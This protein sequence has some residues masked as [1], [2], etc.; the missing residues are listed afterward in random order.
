MIL[1]VATTEP[2]FM[3]I[4]VGGTKVVELVIDD[5]EVEDEDVKAVEPD[6]CEDLELWLIV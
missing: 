4:G 6:N 1:S 5:K 2:L 3:D